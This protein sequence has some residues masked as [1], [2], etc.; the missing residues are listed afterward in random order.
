M[1]DRM[2]R[3]LMLCL[4]LVATGTVLV[5]EDQPV[6]RAR[7]LEAREPGRGARRARDRRRRRRGLG[8]AGEGGNGV[9]VVRLQS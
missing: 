5:L 8:A 7:R 4:V 9:T 6:L 3:T 1:A 2:F